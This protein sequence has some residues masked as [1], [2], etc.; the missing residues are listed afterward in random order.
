MLTNSSIPAETPEH[1]L[2]GTSN[3]RASSSP[4][5]VTPNRDI[6]NYAFDKVFFIFLFFYFIKN[7]NK[8]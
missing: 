6:Q 8:F 2:C 5:F 4:D 7:L 3:K 1:F